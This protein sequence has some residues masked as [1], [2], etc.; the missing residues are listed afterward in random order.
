MQDDETIAQLERYNRSFFEVVRLNKAMGMTI[1]LLG[2]SRA[3]MT[4]PFRSD[5][6]GDPVAGLLHG[7]AITSLLDA[8]CGAAVFMSLDEPDAI[9]TLDLR[10]DYLRRGEPGRDVIAEAHCFKRTRS[11]AFVRSL[12]HHGDPDDPVASAAGA[13]RVGTYM[14]ERGG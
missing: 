3:S 1:D 14:P 7:G 11:V 10:I 8:C 13:F 5:L 12:A 6:V 9:A 4:L 2:P